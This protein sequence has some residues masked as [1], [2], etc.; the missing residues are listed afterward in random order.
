MRRLVSRRSTPIYQISAAPYTPLSEQKVRGKARRLILQND[1]PILVRRGSREVKS[2]SHSNQVR[3]I[4]VD[5]DPLRI[6]LDHQLR[7]RID[8]FIRCK[9]TLELFLRRRAHIVDSY[10]PRVKRR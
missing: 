7:Q 4:G 8:P 1:L 10:P 2:G 5:V 3:N 9:G 6:V